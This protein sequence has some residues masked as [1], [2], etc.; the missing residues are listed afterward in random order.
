MFLAPDDERV[1]GLE[2]E[3]AGDKRFFLPFGTWASSSGTVEVARPLAVLSEVELRFYER[4][5]RRLTELQ[6]GAAPRI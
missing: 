6:A 4:G 2:V 5:A 3:A 1:L